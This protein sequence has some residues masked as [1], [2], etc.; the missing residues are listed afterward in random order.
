M[1]ESPTNPWLAMAD[2]MTSLIEACAGYKAKCEAAGF[3]PTAAEHMALEY[4]NM[5]ITQMGS[6]METNNEQT[7]KGRRG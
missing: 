3:S 5:L 1:P 4:H 6:H 2:T 7:R